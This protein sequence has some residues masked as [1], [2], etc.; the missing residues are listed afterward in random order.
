ME[1][2]TASLDLGGSEYPP[3]RGVYRLE[4]APQAL[5]LG[6]AV[7]QEALRKAAW[8]IGERKS[9]DWYVPPHNLV[10]LGMVHPVQGFAYWRLRSEWV[11]EI[12]GSRGEAWNGARMLL[13]LYDVSYL[14]FNGLNA[15]R[16]QDHD[17]GG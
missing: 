4:G 8:E 6:V 9:G 12:A 1:L 16:I 17:I 2:L 15:H 10:G 11:E 7:D 3:A 5:R 14:E 13:R